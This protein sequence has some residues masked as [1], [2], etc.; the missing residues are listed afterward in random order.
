MSDMGYLGL[1]FLL[2]LIL[3]LSLVQ[4]IA[5]ALIDHR[6]RRGRLDRCLSSAGKK[7]KDVVSATYVLESWRDFETDGGSDCGTRVRG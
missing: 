3:G 2:L 5:L 7:T 4:L 6:M 1:I